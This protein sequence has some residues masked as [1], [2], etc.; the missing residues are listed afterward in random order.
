MVIFEKWVIFRENKCLTSRELYF[1]KIM[2]TRRNG[3]AAL[4]F[5]LENNDS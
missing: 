2:R 4:V 3:S 5:N 1:Q